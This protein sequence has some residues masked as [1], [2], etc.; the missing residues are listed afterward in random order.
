MLRKKPGRGHRATVVAG[1]LTALLASGT[2]ALPTANADTAAA[3]REAAVASARESGAAA[4]EQVAQAAAQASGRPVEVTVLRQERRDVFAN[5]G[6][7]FTARE[8]TQPVRTRLSGSWTPVDDTLVQR[9]DGSLSPKAATVDVRF[10]GGGDGPFARMERAGREYAL[11]WPGSA[12]PKPKVSGDTAQY[13]EVLPGVDL[14]VRAEAEGFAHFLIVKNAEAAADP[15]LTRIELGLSTKGLRIEATPGGGMRA[16]DAAVGGTVFEAAKPVMWDSAPPTTTQQ[17]VRGVVPRA[18]KARLE[19]GESGRTAP[20]GLTVT[21]NKITLTPDIP[22]LRGKDTVYPVVVDPIPKTLSRTAWT[23]VMSGMPSEQDWAYSGSAGMGKCPLDYNPVTCANIGVRRL[24]FTFPLATYS[25]KQILSAQFSGRVE[26][27]Y[28]ATPTAE[29]VELY[30]I[31]GKNRT[32][33]SSSSWSNTK[34]EWG[35][36]PT[37]L[38]AKISPTQCNSAANLNITNGQL[39][40]EVQNAT[41]DSWKSMTLGLKAKDESSYAGWKRLCGNAYLSIEYNTPPKAVDNQ[42]MTSSPGGKCVSGASRPYV[43]VLPL[44]R[45]EARDA[46]NSSSQADQV[47]VQF[48]VWYTDKS[49]KAQNYTADTGYK[50]PNPGTTFSHQVTQRTATTP[51]IQQNSVISWE[52]RAYDGDAWG[53]WSPSRC[54]FIWDATRPKPP[55]V[56]SVEYPDDPMWHHGVGTVGRFTFTAADKDVKEYRYTFDDEA[57]VKKATSGGAPVTVT[58]TPTWAGRHGVTVEAYD[59]ANNSNLVPA[60]YEFL[61]T[62]GKQAVGQWNLDDA[63]GTTAAMDETGRHPG[64]VGTG[65]TF[66]VPGP[67]GPADRAARFNGTTDAYV[68]SW[69]TITDT[70]QSFTASAWVKPATLDRDMAVISQDSTGEPGFVLGYDATLKRWVFSTPDLDVQAMSNW[71]AVASNIEVKADQWVLLTGVFDANAAAGP[72]LRIYVNDVRAGTARRYTTWSSR[73]SLQIGRVQT[74]SGYRN[75]FQ[76]DMTEVRVFD[77]VLPDAQV[78]EME[79]IKPQRKAYWP[80]ESVSGGVS[81]NV[82]TDGQP[83]TLHGG[84]AIY[85][86]ATEFDEAALAGKGHLTLDGTGSWASTASA[87]VTGADSYTVAA[88]VRLTTLDPDKTQT[89]LSLPGQNADRVAVRY[90]AAS[91]QWELALTD[92]DNSTPKVTTVTDDQ[93]LP[94]TD[95]GGQHLAVTFDSLTHE[96]RLYVNGSLRETARGYDHTTWL[97]G[98]GLQVGR[99]ALGGGSGYL[100]GAVDDVRVYVGVAD[101]VTV[102]RMN[103]PSEDV[104]L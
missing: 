4:T 98:G 90:Q 94:T 9:K 81:A 61:V 99:S 49:G 13:E 79:T 18:A 77:R 87:V 53:P 85:N 64:A 10:S 35:S 12:L 37:T 44:L 86:P 6:G 73:R 71:Q 80:L 52:A 22:L 95:I 39:L 100:A 38:N 25:G 15:G 30:R 32:I 19:V 14:A 72:E 58:W 68:D 43:D 66:G 50:S 78:A 46:D 8:Y 31:G 2:V 91:G 54:E 83:L 29:P 63:E 20:V 34:D 51:Q 26:H 75:Q 89:V 59:G 62:D 76:G 11:T 5:P 3:P 60:R 57:T 65:V 103:V 24:L 92:A 74:K 101:P 104:D 55:A 47:K 93:Q 27:I 28:S 42:L 36:I 48:R 17:S 70:G 97:S 69:G 56:N 21:K 45:A 33:T 41:G 7:T 67:G 40:T 84:A 96:V 23:S 88:R 102:A 16:V 82:Q 1:V